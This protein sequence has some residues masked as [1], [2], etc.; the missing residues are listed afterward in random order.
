MFGSL[1]AG[2]VVIVDIQVGAYATSGETPTTEHDN[3]AHF[4]RV[5]GIDW[6][7]EQIYIENTLSGAASW[8]VSL[9]TFGDVWQYPEINVSPQPKDITPEGVN[10]WALTITRQ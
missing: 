1:N 3:F 2:K 8:T 5:L 4:A 7:S 10:Q 6:Q 9:A